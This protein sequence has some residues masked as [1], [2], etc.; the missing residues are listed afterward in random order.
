VPNRVHHNDRHLVAAGLVM[1]NGLSEEDDP[2]LHKV[3]IVSDNIKHLAAADTL[4]L[5]V[6]VVKAGAFLN[7]LFQAAPARVAQAV[8]KSLSDLKNPPYS[9]AELVAALRLHGANE[10]ANGL[11][12]LTT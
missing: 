6:E 5:G 10:V 9:M 8:A 1:V 7:R 2:S 3:M 11:K 12:R 4:K